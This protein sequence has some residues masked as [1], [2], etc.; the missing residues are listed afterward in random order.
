VEAKTKEKA[1]TKLIADLK[2]AYPSNIWMASSMNELAPDNN[3]YQ[4]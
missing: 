1:V 3:V 4:K 2:N